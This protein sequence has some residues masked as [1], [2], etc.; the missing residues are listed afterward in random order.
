MSMYLGQMICQRDPDRAAER[1]RSFFDGSRPPPPPFPHLVDGILR[2][3]ADGAPAPAAGLLGPH[4]RV[5]LDGREGRLDDLVGSGVVL[6]LRGPTPALSRHGA[7]LLTRLD[8]RVVALAADGSADLDGRYDAFLREHGLA[9][10]LVRPDFYLFGGVAELN[11]IDGLL[12]DL[13]DQIFASAV[14]VQQ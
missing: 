1:D 4:G 9:A 12:Q 14:A 6:I 8:I 3:A 7:A 10:M 5:R 2:R 11:Q 13:A